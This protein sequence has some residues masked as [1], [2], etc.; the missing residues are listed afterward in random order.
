MS[1]TE[2]TEGVTNRQNT[3]QMIIN[4]SIHMTPKSY[5]C[6]SWDSDPRP[7]AW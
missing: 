3:E 7:S 5:W 4:Y 2:G 6:A 1:M